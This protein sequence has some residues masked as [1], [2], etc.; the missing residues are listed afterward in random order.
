MNKKYKQVLKK[1]IDIIK[2]MYP[3]L[4]VAVR[5][6]GDEIFVRISS[7]EISDEAEYEALI[8]DFYEEY[9]R[10]ILGNIFWGVDLSLTKDDLHL[11]EDPIKVPK[12]ENL[13]E[14]KPKK[15]PLAQAHG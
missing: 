3:E 6:H 2:S 15:M 4:Y 5:M 8:C 1:H 7:L 13:K 9:D 11:L 14:N 12:K 10:K